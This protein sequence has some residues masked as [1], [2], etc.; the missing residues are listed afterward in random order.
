MALLILGINHRTAPVEIR[1]K[2]VF[3][4]AALPH[5]L[6]ALCGLKSVEE[7]VIVSTCNRTEL[8]VS[9]NADGSGELADW[10]DGHHGAAGSI[11]D[12]LYLLRDR[13]AVS[14]CFAV[15]SGLDS[16]IVGEPQILGQ[17]KEAFRAAAGQ[18][19]VGPVLNRLFQ[20]AFSVAKHVRTRTRIGA[21]AVS[22]AY[23]AVSLARQIFAGF[24]RH[25][26]LLVGAG[27]TIELVAQHLHGNGLARM[28]VANRNPERAQ[29]LATRFSGFGIP[30]TDLAAHLAEADILICSTA[31]SE[32]L[33]T[34]DMMKTAIKARK[35]RPMFIGDIAVPRDVEARVAD[36]EDVYLY[37]IDDLQNV[38]EENLRSRHRAANQARE[39]VD[40][41]A[42]RFDLT[43]RTLDAVPTIRGL[44]E[45]AERIGA[46]A[47]RQAQRQLASGR[48]PAEIL[49]HL[50]AR[51][52]K[53]LL[54]TPSLRLRRAGEEGDRALI[55]AARELFALDERVEDDLAETR[56]DDFGLTSPPLQEEDEVESSPLPHREEGKGP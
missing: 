56:S 48:D 9:A 55:D 41:E 17:L 7:A 49:G 37:T 54:H 34:Y 24:E 35:H 3:D 21:N 53:K 4:E 13:E 29:A 38:V 40:A 42:L 1:E 18:G 15:A 45:D 8:Y 28:I 19:A 26:A 30:L 33:I 2:I 50:A 43:S 14:H 11:R 22:V 20:Q 5:G 27:E 46:E 47:V 6:A 51:L 36:L 12:R 39:L 52:T 31:G 16:M 44:R 25:T 23:A 10:L 32:V